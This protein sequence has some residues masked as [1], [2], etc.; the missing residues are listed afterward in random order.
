VTTGRG[1]QTWQEFLKRD[2]YKKYQRSIIF[3]P[4]E[5]LVSAMEDSLMLNDDFDLKYRIVKVL[6][7]S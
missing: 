5:S 1:R 3:R 2:E 7:G 4:I 6:F